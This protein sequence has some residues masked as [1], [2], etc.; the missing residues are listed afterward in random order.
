MK[1]FQFRGIASKRLPR[2]G[3]E[4]LPC[5]MLRCR[6]QRKP[7]AYCWMHVPIPK[8]KTQGQ[9]KQHCM[10]HAGRVTWKLFT[11]WCGGEQTRPRNT[12]RVATHH[13]NLQKSTAT[14]TLRKC[15]WRQKTG[16]ARTRHP[17]VRAVPVRLCGGHAVR[18]PF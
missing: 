13:C 3:L 9:M 12:P 17:K 4:E 7:S 15:S 6:G 8:F 1:G 10:L 11:Y 18:R 14:K 16:F 5:T 2:I